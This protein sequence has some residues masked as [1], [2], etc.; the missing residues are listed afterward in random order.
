MNYQ[1]NSLGKSLRSI[2]LSAILGAVLALIPFYFN[3]KSAL[4]IHSNEIQDLKTEVHA[5]ERT[6]KATEKAVSEL[7]N[8]PLLNDEKIKSIDQRL[9]RIEKKIDY[10]IEKN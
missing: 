9:N 6:D 4:E 2:L 5:L 1:L 8:K 3:S 7:E 10:L